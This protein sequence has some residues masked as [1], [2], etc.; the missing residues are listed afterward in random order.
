MH[1]LFEAKLA[2]LQQ[3]KEYYKAAATSLPTS[4]TPIWSEG[5]DDDTTSEDSRST[6]IPWYQTPTKS[7]SMQHPEG[8]PF[9][10]SRSQASSARTSIRA[11]KPS[12]LRIRKNLDL[13][14]LPVTPPKTNSAAIFHQ[15][16]HQMQEY[17][18]FTPPNKLKLPMSPPSS[19]PFSV[20]FSESSF[21]WLHQRSNKRYQRCLADFAD[22][23]QGHM[24]AVENF[25]GHIKDIQA[26]RHVG[27]LASFG[28][29]KEARVADLRARIVRLR[30]NGW[31]R[32]RFRP[33]RYQ[34]LCE[35]AL[36][37]L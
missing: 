8:S 31:R 4:E 14:V 30:A 3:A 36:A 34:D 26:N 9:L 18:P 37:E 13:T 17:P 29:D 10:P 21:R 2:N 12:P 32:E 11:L 22:M 24:A 20:T 1:D 23:L 15:D 7:R 5:W 19:R 6:E 35:T 16:S 25:I 27:R 28:A 33:G